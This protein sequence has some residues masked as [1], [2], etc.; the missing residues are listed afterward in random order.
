MKI[1]LALLLLLATLILAS[2]TAARKIP[3]KYGFYSTKSPSLTIE[4]NGL[5]YWGEYKTSKNAVTVHSYYYSGRDGAQGAWVELVNVRQDWE[6][7]PKKVPGAKLPNTG[8]YTREIAGD[9]YYCRTFLVQPNSGKSGFATLPVYTAI[10]IC[11]K[12]ISSKQKI[13]IGYAAEVDA[14][15]AGKIFNSQNYDQLTQAQIDFF[16]A[17]DE[18]ADDALMMKKFQ[19][20]DVSDE[21]D[22]AVKLDDPWYKFSDY[23]DMDRLIGK[24]SR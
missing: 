2:C 24:I 14:E 16:A 1:I 10:R 21:I 22:A 9:R 11:T 7:R 8:V 15:L 20:G 12:L 3:G 4:F 18:R 5:E 23:I 17:F 19:K 13:S 6:L